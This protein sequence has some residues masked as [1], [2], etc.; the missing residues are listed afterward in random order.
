M[1]M[2]KLRLGLL[3]LGQVGSGVYSILKEKQ[4]YLASE[5]GVQF[6]IQKIA[7][8]NPSKKR[9]V[10]VPAG[11]LTRDA[12][13]IVR[14]PSIDVV[15]E[16]MGGVGEAGRLV[17]EA[18][19]NGKHVVTAN[20]ALLAEDGDEIFNLAARLKRWVL[21]EAS[22]GGGIPVVKSLREGLV[23]NRFESIHAIINGTSNY[24]LSQMSEGGA[25]FGEALKSAQQKGY[26]EADP[27]LDIDGSDAAHKLAILVRV[28]FGGKVRFKDIYREGIQQIRAEDIAFAR[29]FG[30][31]V[32]LLA[33]AK[34]SKEGIEVRVQPTLLP[35]DH[36][37]ANVN[38]SFNA[39]LMDGDKTGP[40]LLYGRGAGS[41]PT[42]SAVI[43]DLVDLAKRY[44]R[45]DAEDALV[46]RGNSRTLK[47]LNISS[48]MSRYYLRFHVVDQPGVLG[49]ISRVLGVHRISISDC[50]QRESRIGS[51][52]SLIMLTHHAH[53]S[54]IRGAIRAIDKLGVVKG[55]SQLIRMEE[56]Q[57]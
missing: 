45:L 14:D 39:V 54:S 32:K 31:R 3:G 36:I 35:K 17:K 49:K 37:L 56:N 9:S 10:R 12:Y 55:K 13:S 33:I 43:S 19:R 27:T 20:K 51:V 41:L 25:D 11:L 48:L 4:A 40:V 50:Y 5:V 30:Y 15:V 42:A 24:I 53:E 46:F 18:L 2:K 57:G 52:V 38:G 44:D 1:V 26:A 34:N 47:L 7:V 6:T 29:E 21:F 8:K 22:V 16:L 28:G 23:A